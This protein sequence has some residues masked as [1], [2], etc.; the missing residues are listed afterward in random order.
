MKRRGNTISLASGKNFRACTAVTPT[1]KFHSQGKSVSGAGSCCA[2]RATTREREG[3]NKR[4]WGIPGL[5]TRSGKPGHSPSPDFS[6]GMPHSATTRSS[7]YCNVKIEPKKK[8]SIHFLAPQYVKRGGI[9]GGTYTFR[10][11]RNLA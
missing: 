7:K 1:H 6:A 4:R 10:R 2:Y 9:Y 3:K 8:H 11:E 5:N